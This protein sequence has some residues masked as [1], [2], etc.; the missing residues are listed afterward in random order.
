MNKIA[1]LYRLSICVCTYIVCIHIHAYMHAYIDTYIH[2]YIHAYIRIYI[3]TC[4]M[5]KLA[6]PS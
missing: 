1:F 2:R 3:Y 6:R 4:S 5:P